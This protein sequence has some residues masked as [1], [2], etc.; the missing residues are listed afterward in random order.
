MTY[1][2][3]SGF[4]PKKCRCMTCHLTDRKKDAATIINDSRG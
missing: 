1:G 4:A 2:V 3:E